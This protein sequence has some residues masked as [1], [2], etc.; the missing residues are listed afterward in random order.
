VLT[1]DD[2]RKAD[3]I[4]E[5]DRKSHLLIRVE[6]TEPDR[7][8]KPSDDQSKTERIKT[9]LQMRNSNKLRLAYV[10]GPCWMMEI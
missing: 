10:P 4:A 9:R 2:F 1:S 6:G 7:V 8:L 5:L 3:E